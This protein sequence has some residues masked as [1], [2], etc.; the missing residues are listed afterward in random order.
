MHRTHEKNL[1]SNVIK[2]KKPASKRIGKKQVTK[3]TNK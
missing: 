2:T 1:A 3:K